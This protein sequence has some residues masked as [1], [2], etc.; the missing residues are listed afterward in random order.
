[1]G[2]KEFLG[3]FEQMVLL[4]VLQLGEESAY[5]VAVRK[6]IERRTGRAVSRGS[7]YVTLDRLEKKGL[8]QSQFADPTPERGGKAKKMF[9]A[10]ESGKE[11][12]KASAEALARMWEGLELVRGEK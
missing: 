1:M 12:L 6:E 2:E 5:G 3:E 4:S 7:V 8:L 10:T 11:A 9:A